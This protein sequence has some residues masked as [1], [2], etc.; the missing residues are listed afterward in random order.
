[1]RPKLELARFP[2]GRSPLGLKARSALALGHLPLR[3]GERLGLNQEALALVTAPGPAEFY[4]DRMP[5]AL[6]L[7]AAGEQRIAG[8]EEFQVAEAGA[9]EAG[10]AWILHDQESAG[11]AA[12]VAGPLCLPA[13]DD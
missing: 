5:R 6:R 13:L 7:G 1:M 11:A 12:A 4:D 9:V 2:G 10:R 8:T 3:L